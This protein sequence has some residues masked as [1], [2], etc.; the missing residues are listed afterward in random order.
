M[1]SERTQAFVSTS[2]I[3]R[4][5]AVARG[6]CTTNSGTKRGPLKRGCNSTLEDASNRYRWSLLSR[7]SMSVIDEQASSV[8]DD[9]ER[10]P[11]HVAGGNRR[12]GFG[13][14]TAEVE[15]PRR[16]VSQAPTRL[17]AAMQTYEGSAGAARS[18]RMIRA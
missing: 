6:C 2:E 8:A 14:R 1:F 11:R 5:A 16:A 17:I 7:S 15:N 10:K 4:E 18:G 12:P 13:Q 3:A 9:A